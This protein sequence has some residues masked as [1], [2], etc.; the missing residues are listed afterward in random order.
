[1]Y[2]DESLKCQLNMPM[3]STG[4]CK[5]NS[6]CITDVCGMCPGVMGCATQVCKDGMCTFSCPVDACGGCATGEI[7]VHQTGGPPG[8]VHYVCATRNPCG[9]ASACSCIVGQG[10]CS[11]AMVD[12]YCECDNGLE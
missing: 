7:C 10:T 6:E 11:P 1:M 8:G 5:D 12:G 4:G 3:C 2:C 9:A